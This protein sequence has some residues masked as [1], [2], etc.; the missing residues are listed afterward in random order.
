MSKIVL[1]ILGHCFCIW[2]WVL[3]VQSL[4]RI[5]LGFW[6]GLHWICRL[7]LVRLLFLLC[8]C[9]V[10]KSMGDLSIFCYLCQFLSFFKDLEF[11]SYRSFTCLLRVIPTYFML[12]LASVM[13]LWFLSQPIYHSYI[14]GLLIFELILYPVILLKMFTSCRSSW[15]KFLWPLMCTTISSE[16]SENLTSFPIC[17]PL[18]SFCCLITVVRTSSTILN[19]YGESG[20]LCLVPDLCGIHLV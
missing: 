7:L 12:L 10:S 17:I 11:L 6:W 18:I 19:R 3:F 15:V 20:Q 14:G 9:F 16:N 5:F 1:S 2:T 13:I 4:W 8:W